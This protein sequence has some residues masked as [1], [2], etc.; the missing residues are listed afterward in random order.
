VDEDDRRAGAGFLVVEL[1]AIIGSGVGHSGL[2]CPAR[3]ALATIALLA[4]A[5]LLVEQRLEPRKA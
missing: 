4:I 5:V 1:H 2:R 3:G